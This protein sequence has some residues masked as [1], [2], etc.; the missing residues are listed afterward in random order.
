VLLLLQ[1]LWLVGVTIKLSGLLQS[2]LLAWL[3]VAP[4]KHL[5]Q[6]GLFSQR[7]LP[8]IC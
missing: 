7:I 3:W 4:V 1:Q 6:Q 2:R 8:T 5:L